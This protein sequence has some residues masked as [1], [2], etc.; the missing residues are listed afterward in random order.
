MPNVQRS[1]LCRSSRPRAA[2]GLSEDVNNSGGWRGWSGGREQLGC[3]MF[4]GEGGDDSAGGGHKRHTRHTVGCREKWRRSL[5]GG[6]F[7]LTLLTK[8]VA[9][10]LEAHLGLLHRVRPDA[11]DQ[12]LALGSQPSYHP[13]RTRFRVVLRADPIAEE[14]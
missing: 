3:L 9:Y 11:F 1:D 6:A 12:R 13:T 10:F 8:A 4:G 14:K 2:A 7:T 5:M